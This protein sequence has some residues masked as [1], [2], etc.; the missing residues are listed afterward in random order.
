[1]AT[2]IGVTLTALSSAS[3]STKL[4]L[5]AALILLLGVACWVIGN[6]GRTSNAAKIIRTLQGRTTRTD[7]PRRRYGPQRRPGRR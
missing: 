4:L 1:M 7:G 5:G 6:D 3:L 2:L